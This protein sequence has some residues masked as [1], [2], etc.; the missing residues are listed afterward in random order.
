MIIVMM[1]WLSR[2]R[3]WSRQ[4]MLS[5]AFYFVAILA[6]AA[7]GFMYFELPARPELSWGDAVWWAFVTTTTV[8]YGD[9]YPETLGGRMLVGVPVML[10]GIGLLGYILS[11]LSASLI[12]SRR[13]VMRGMS[14]FKFQD[15][16][17]LVHYE[18]LSACIDLV[19]EL[20]NDPLM[21]RCPMV[22]VDESLKELPVELSQR[23]VHFVRGQPSRREVLLRANLPQARTLIL[24][25]DRQEQS[26]ADHRNLAV[27][28]LAKKIAPEIIMV[29]HCA[30]PDHRE[31]FESAGCSRVVCT[32]A[33]THQL[34][35]QELHDPGI[36]SVLGELTS[37][38]VGSEIYIISLSPGYAGQRFAALCAAFA[39]Q[40]VVT[41]GV[42]R[43]GQNYLAPGLDFQLS[44]SDAAVVI[45]ADRPHLPELSA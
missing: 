35:V 1:R 33:L 17:I 43:D 12:E 44:A 23:G 32:G 4:G 28:V 34:M 36:A 7:T 19:D 29:V 14:S 5:V 38:L 2:V 9:Y 40:N 41:I 16:V 42:R 20:R 31:F 26:H 21:D 45:S 37:N 13:G 6:Y 8:G 25:A 39:E 15:H 10:L 22:L 30:D 3:Y 27:C 11:V 18:G 24:N